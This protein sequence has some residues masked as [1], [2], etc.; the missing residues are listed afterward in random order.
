M[1]LVSYV[2][3]VSFITGLTGSKNTAAAS[4]KPSELL[5]VTATTAAL[6]SFIE[7]GT[8]WLGCYLLNIG[9]EARFLDVIAIVG[10]K[11]IGYVAD[12]QTT[13]VGFYT[14]R[15]VAT[16]LFSLCIPSSFGSVLIYVFFS[17]CLISMAFFFV[18]ISIICCSYFDYFI[19]IITVEPTDSCEV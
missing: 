10:Y 5:S 16:A 3:L 15:L 17:Y 6:F 11:Y 1:S 8:I 12:R 18:K 13:I 2:L 19:I 7:A 14:C 9:R 4:F